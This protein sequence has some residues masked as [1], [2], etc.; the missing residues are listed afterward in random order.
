MTT[1][2][3]ILALGTLLPMPVLCFKPL[4]CTRRFGAEQLI[5]TIKPLKQCGCNQSALVIRN[6]RGC[7]A[8]NLLR[9][10]WKPPNSRSKRIDHLLRCLNIDT[11]I[12]QQAIL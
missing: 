12:F 6:G 4:K 9:A 5:V 8:A 3:L 11:Q 1:G 2:Q 7:H 10:P